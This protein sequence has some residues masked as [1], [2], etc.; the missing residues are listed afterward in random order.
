MAGKNKSKTKKPRGRPATGVDP[1]VTFR[2]PETEIADLDAQAEAAGLS[3]SAAIRQLV[4]NGLKVGLKARRGASA[5]T[6]ARE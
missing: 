4:E 6:A 1:L 5:R 3:R 2:L